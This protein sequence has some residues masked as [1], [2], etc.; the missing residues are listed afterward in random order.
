MRDQPFQSIKELDAYIS[1]ER[2]QC[3]ECGRWFRALGAHLTSAHGMTHHDYREKWA[4]PRRYP[5]A[6]TATR[7][8]LSSQI[9]DMIASG[10]L[11]YEHL[12][13]AADASR[14]ADR[15][16][17][18][19]IDDV[20]HRKIIA[21]KR[22][23]DHHKLPPGAKRADGRNADRRREYQIAYRALKQ[24]D[25]KPMQHYREKYQC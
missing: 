7:E 2:I 14:G 17:K 9:Q 20:R 11:T 4:I 10:R 19:E 15:R 18:M 5:L 13:S 6:G 12:P 1:G 8:I 23:G 24:G 3:L 16:R 25:P 22:P 21:E